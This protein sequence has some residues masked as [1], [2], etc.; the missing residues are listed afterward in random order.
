MLVSS[1]P[2]AK[3]YN[4]HYT[5]NL[6]KSLAEIKTHSVIIMVDFNQGIHALSDFVTL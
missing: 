6:Y 2:S 4:I 5:N 1:S 3:E